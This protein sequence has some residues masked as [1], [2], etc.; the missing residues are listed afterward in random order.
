MMRLRSRGVLSSLLVTSAVSI[1]AAC[2]SSTSSNGNPATGDGGGGQGGQG[3]T[4]PTCA[5]LTHLQSVMADLL[6][7]PGGVTVVTDAP[8][9]DASGALSI[10]QVAAMEDASRTQYSMGDTAVFYYLVISTN[11]T[12]DNSAGSILGEAYRPSAMVVFQ[13]TS[14]ANSGGLGQPSRD[15][16]ESTVVAHE[17]GHILGLVN[18]GT[19]MQTPHEDSRASEARREH[20]VP[21]VLGEQL[22][23]GPREPSHGR[24]RPRL[25]REL[26]CRCCGVE[27]LIRGLRR[28]MLCSRAMNFVR[29]WVVIL[30][31]TIMFACGSS[32]PH[33]RTV[34]NS[35][36]D[37]GA[38]RSRKR[39]ARHDGLCFVRARFV[40]DERSRVA[41][42]RSKRRLCGRRRRRFCRHAGGDHSEHAMLA[43]GHGW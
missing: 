13:K 37:C 14:D 22:E 18:T 9:D 33:A 42:D 27:E 19:P 16:V 5:A 12:D 4:N 20:C 23:R 29:G 11:S 25:R 26:P 10:A 1:L 39:R 2:S 6:D 30:M 8:V 34:A 35:E 15:V 3:S 40:L 17:F 21:D 31:I 36:N 7:K 43:F 24:K 41:T 38:A 32:S 28:I